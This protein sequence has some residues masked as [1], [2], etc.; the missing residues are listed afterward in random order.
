MGGLVKDCSKEQR[1]ILYIDIFHVHCVLCV[2]VLHTKTKEQ[3]KETNT[4]II[5]A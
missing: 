4:N 5:K 2:C 3:A 1:G